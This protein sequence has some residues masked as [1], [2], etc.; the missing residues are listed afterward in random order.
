MRL[1]KISNLVFKLFV[2]LPGLAFLFNGL[3]WLVEPQ[4]AAGSM[5]MPLLNDGAGLSSQIGDIG[6]L[7]LAMGLMI[8]TAIT[9]SNGQWLRPVVLLLLCIAFYRLV[10][11]IAHDA[12]LLRQMIMLELLLALW[13]HFAANKLSPK[14]A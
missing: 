11:F 3:N 12:A 14:N 8:L 9:T 10:A 6:G 1:Q 5:M 13:L 4:V 2:V 7:F